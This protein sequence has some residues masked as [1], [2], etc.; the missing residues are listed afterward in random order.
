[1]ASQPERIASLETTASIAKWV[2]GIFIPLVIVWGAFVTM[3]VIAIKQQLADGN[4]TKLVTELETP[5]SPQQLQANLTTVTAQIQTARVNGIKPN[6]KKV[7]ALSRAIS[8]VVVHNPDLPE[9]WHATT[10]LISY[11]SE[12][13]HPTPEHLPSCNF[14]GIQP[15]MREWERKPNGDITMGVGFFF[16]NCSMKLEDVPALTMPEDKVPFKWVHF[17]D[18]ISRFTVYLTNGEVIYGGGQLQHESGF[19]F[20]NCAF[21]L[22]TISIPDN[23]AQAVLVAALKSHDLSSVS[24]ESTKPS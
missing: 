14:Q 3:N 4:N 2:L 23:A 7:V 5:K 6:E 17:V 19:A 24:T 20:K 11:R 16:S 10:E 8:Q 15:E 13:A 1:M 21:N 22:Q 12:I 18:G 9:A